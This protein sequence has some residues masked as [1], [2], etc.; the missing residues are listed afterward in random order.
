MKK[1]IFIVILLLIVIAW[2][3]VDT[4]QGAIKQKKSSE[5]HAI[6]VAKEEAGLQQITGVNTYYGTN[7]YSVVRGTDD[8]S[9]KLIVW[10]PSKK[11]NLIVK[12]S[13]DGISKN[14][15]LQ[16]LK[17]NQHPK[18]IINIVLGI[19]ENQPIWEITYIDQRNRYSFYYID[20]ESGKFIKRY[21][22]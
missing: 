12:E 7:V 8:L 15:A 17:D 2:Q 16:I 5:A 11:G 9:R 13:S 3:S 20:F 4:Y 1:W 21:S 19:E 6:M 18:K 10:V 22:L 14:N